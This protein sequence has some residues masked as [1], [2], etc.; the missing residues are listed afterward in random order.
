M[1]NAPIVTRRLLM[2]LS[3]LAAISSFAKEPIAPGVQLYTVRNEVVKQP[4]ATLQ[5]IAEIG[6][7]EAEMLRNQVKPLAPLLKRV[8]LAPVSLHFETPLL[9]GNW[10]AWQHADM[11][12]I[13]AGV[14]Y[15]ACVSL[16]RDHG[17]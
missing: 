13:E 9:T 8:N 12:P 3:G 4:L 14:T 5:A 10:A 6:Y 15:D 2:K 1:T 17:L 16:A 7:R 11:P